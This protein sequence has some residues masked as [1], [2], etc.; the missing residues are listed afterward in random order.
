MVLLTAWEGQSSHNVHEGWPYMTASCIE[1]STL[2]RYPSNLTQPQRQAN[3]DASCLASLPLCGDSRMLSLHPQAT[4]GSVRM[5]MYM[6]SHTASA[7][8]SEQR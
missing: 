8:R 2:A 6:T 4:Y 3:N 5:H 7:G 1:F